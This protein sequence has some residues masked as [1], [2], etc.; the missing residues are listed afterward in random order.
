MSQL[1]NLPWPLVAVFIT[2]SALKNIFSFLLN[3]AKNRANLTYPNWNCKVRDIE[4][5][6]SPDLFKEMNKTTTS[7]KEDTVTK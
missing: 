3:I 1:K 5:L 7:T 4:T 2:K 6:I